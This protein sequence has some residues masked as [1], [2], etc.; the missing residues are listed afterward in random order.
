T[1][2]DKDTRFW[3]YHYLPW[4]IVH[5]HCRTPT[6]I[7]K[8]WA[9]SSLKRCYF[10]IPQVNFSAVFF[11]FH[12]EVKILLSYGVYHF[13][14]QYFVLIDVGR[15]AIALNANFHFH[16][17]IYKIRHIRFYLTFLVRV[18]LV[19][20]KSKSVK[21]IT[22][23]NINW[24]AVTQWIVSSY[25][26]LVV[27]TEIYSQTILIIGKGQHIK[28]QGEVL[29]NSDKFFDFIGILIIKF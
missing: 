5:R 4:G 6:Y 2:P 1:Y 3:I 25:A 22:S 10:N 7:T 11:V 13:R 21:S 26:F 18:N 12:S 27:K 17:I 15:H 9:L 29:R 20:G 16:N 24:I 14:I 8:I 28:F 19:A 23:L